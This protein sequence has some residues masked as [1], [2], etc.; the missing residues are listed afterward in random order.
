VAKEPH[1]APDTGDGSPETRVRLLTPLSSGAIAVVQLSGPRALAIGSTIFRPRSGK[2]LVDIP[3]GR[4][5]YGDFI[6]SG[7]SLLDDGFAICGGTADQPWV[8]FQ[9]HGGV[10]I[11]QRLIRRMTDLGAA[12]TSD[13]D[14]S[15]ADRA[16]EWL[17]PLDRWVQQC[18]VQAATPRVVEWLSRQ[19]ELW[20]DRLSDW[21]RH[22]GAGDPQSVLIDAR[23][24]LA[25]SEQGRAW[26]GRTLAIIGLPN[27]GKSTL[28][29]RL[30]G[31]TVS[32][33]AEGPGTTRDWVGE[34]IAIGG[35]PVTLVDTA[36]LRASHD[37]VEA[38]GVVRALVQA[39]QADARLLVVDNS[40]A[41]DAS[42]DWLA[43]QTGLK[44]VE[45]VAFTKDDLPAGRSSLQTL[46]VTALAAVR[47]SGLTGAGWSSLEGVL[48]EALGFAALQ[49]REPLVFCSQLREAVARVASALG[50]GR[51]AE[52]LAF[53][54]ALVVAV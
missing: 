30:A 11:V 10:R 22:A 33:V 13:D 17:C 41:P 34:P 21:R 5:V 14:A 54:Q 50:D 49:D 38:E 19:S 27:A 36:G 28:A 53:L 35:W 29:N 20:H 26:R 31:R 3:P 37:P 4:V 42:E 51:V 8:E 32:L 39:R 24:L 2:P 52:T 16:F 25:C 12:L 18:L 6:D 1:L 9:L 23:R 46:P 7:D 44:S 15:P 43:A 48:L 47:V 45:V 40:C